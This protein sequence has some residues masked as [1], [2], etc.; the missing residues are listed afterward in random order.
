[1][2][3]HFGLGDASQIEKVA[4]RWPS[5]L[6]QS[7]TGVAVDHIYRVVEGAPS[8]QEFTAKGQP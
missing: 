6:N 8:A 7:L 5:G 4:I 2:R 3:V 1:M